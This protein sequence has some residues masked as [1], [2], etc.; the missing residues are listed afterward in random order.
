MRINPHKDEN[1]GI[2]EGGYA[3][4]ANS[5]SETGIKNRK[6]HG[7]H[8]VSFLTMLVSIFLCLVG[9]NPSR[10][11]LPLNRSF[12]TQ[13]T[14]NCNIRPILSIPGDTNL[15]LTTLSNQALLLLVSCAEAQNRARMSLTEDL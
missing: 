11:S 13:T 10:K 12:P 14:V 2:H 7:Y 6:Y 8:I 15:D 3:K 1:L 4:R 9:T 5:N